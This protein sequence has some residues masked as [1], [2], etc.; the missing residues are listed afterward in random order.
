ML[1]RHGE[2]KTTGCCSAPGG[3]KE[4]FDASLRRY[5]PVPQPPIGMRACVRV[6]P[7]QAGSKAYRSSIQCNRLSGTFWSHTQHFVHASLLVPEV[8]LRPFRQGQIC[9]HDSKSQALSGTR[10]T[11]AGFTENSTLSG[12]RSCGS[13]CRF[14]C[15]LLFFFPKH[16]AVNHNTKQDQRKN[17]QNGQHDSKDGSEDRADQFCR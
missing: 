1:G 6:V 13:L 9:Q 14:L 17:S 8:V 11:E 12:S 4:I 7:R 10:K 2:G 16:P 15:L 5:D 3:G